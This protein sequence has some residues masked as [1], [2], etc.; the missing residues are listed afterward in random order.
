MVTVPSTSILPRL[1]SF[2][3]GNTFGKN[4]MAFP[5]IAA[6]SNPFLDLN[7]C[8]FS[9]QKDKNKTARVVLGNLIKDTGS[10]YTY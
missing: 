10:A 9:D 2:F 1:N 4:N 7:S 6:K 8:S 5:Y 3:Y